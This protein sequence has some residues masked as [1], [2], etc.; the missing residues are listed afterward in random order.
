M[1]I[2]VD[3]SMILSRKLKIGEVHHVSCKQTGGFYIQSIT[4]HAA[5][6]Q[7]IRHLHKYGAEAVQSIDPINRSVRLCE[8]QV[9]KPDPHPELIRVY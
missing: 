3:V 6:K 9:N 4:Q 1:W 8:T 7:K 5:H 2:R